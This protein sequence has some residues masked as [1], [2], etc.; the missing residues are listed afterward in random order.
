[1]IDTWL[2]LPLPALLGAMA[3][4]YCASAAC[5]VWLC[6]GRTTG[7]MVQSF[8]GVVGPFIGSIAVILAILIGFLASDIWD[9]ER[10]A[11]AAVRAEADQLLALNTLAKT[12]GVP[13]DTIGPAIHTYAATVV[14]KEWPSMERQ[15][16]SPEAEAAFDQILKTIDDLHL[17]GA[18]RGELDRLMFDTALS[19][20]SARSTR[21]ALARD[22]SASLK[23][24]SVLVLA[25]MTQ[26]SVA[27]VQL[28]KK[29]PQIAALATLT[30]SIIVVI[31]MLAAHELP[32]AP[33]LAVTPDPLVHVLGVIPAG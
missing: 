19:I 25:V 5:L 18:G 32:F 4:F 3:L 13:R 17:A 11:T 21:L 27:L 12:F 15:E 22:G 8:K 31:G 23:W 29:R 10:R 14:N 16:A 7:P 26:V 24:M 6:F 33:P 30:V 1:M 20:R 2:A 9:R 28:E